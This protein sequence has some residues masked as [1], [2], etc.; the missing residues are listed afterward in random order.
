[1]SH[2]FEVVGDFFFLTSCTVFCVTCVFFYY[3]Y[4][5]EFDIIF[6]VP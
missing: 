2:A 4:Y 6:S 5:C 1:M 3:I